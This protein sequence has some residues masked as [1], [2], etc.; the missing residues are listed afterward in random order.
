MSNI[1]EKIDFVDLS[2]KILFIVLLVVLITFIPIILYTF[3]FMSLEILKSML[4]DIS[5]I[6]VSC[7]VVAGIILLIDGYQ[8]IRS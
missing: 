6:T 3:N 7:V 5:K 4:P 8:I 2:N 1:I